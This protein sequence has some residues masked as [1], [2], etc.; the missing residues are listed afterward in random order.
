MRPTYPVQVVTVLSSVG[1]VWLDVDVMGGLKKLR[2]L[3]VTILIR[4]R[5][6][7]RYRYILPTYLFT[8]SHAFS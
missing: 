5:E 2:S 4:V 7:L 3:I 8:E 6:G 1:R